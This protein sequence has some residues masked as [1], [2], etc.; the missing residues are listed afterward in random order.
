MIETIPCDQGC[1]ASM[2]TFADITTCPDCQL[3]LDRAQMS[4][5][6]KAAQWDEA[7]SWLDRVQLRYPL[8]S[9]DTLERR[10]DGSVAPG[11]RVV[12]SLVVSVVTLVGMWLLRRKDWRGWLVGLC[13]Q[14]L[15]LVLIIQTHAWG[16]LLL[17]GALI[18]IY[19]RGLIEW[20]REAL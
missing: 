8:N 12:L 3:R 5:N 6:E 4:S 11:E 15:W 18:Y 13:N 10:L 1:G 14:S 9:R 20:R 17:T 16:L 2:F 7:M 19:T